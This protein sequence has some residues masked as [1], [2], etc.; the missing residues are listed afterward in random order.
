MDSLKLSK[1]VEPFSTHCIDVHSNHRE[2]SHSL[3]KSS[4]PE[5]NNPKP[6]QTALNKLETSQ[7]IEN[8]FLKPFE[9]ISN[10]LNYLKPVK[11]S[12]KPFQTPLDSQEPLHLNLRRF[13]TLG[14]LSNDHAVQHAAST[15]MSCPPFFSLNSFFIVLPKSSSSSFFNTCMSTKNC[16]PRGR[17]SA[18]TAKESKKQLLFIVGTMYHY[19]CH[20]RVSCNENLL[21]SFSPS[22][23]SAVSSP[24]RGKKGI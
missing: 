6:F 9:I 12:S 7:T 2:T 17:E 8:F 15:C 1:H 11:T 22:L 23:F 24:F 18:S 20:A 3:L 5:Q 4:K 10:Q 21:D 13:E 19:F 16:Q 14:N